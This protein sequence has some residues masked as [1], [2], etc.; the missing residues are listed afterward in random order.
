[1]RAQHGQRFGAIRCQRHL[2]TVAAQKAID[3]HSIQWI[4][5]SDEDAASRVP[6]VIA[7][8]G[9]CYCFGVGT[10]WSPHDLNP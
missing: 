4:I 2:V 9:G 3:H 8:I 6:I 10:C 5:V 1:M 7:A